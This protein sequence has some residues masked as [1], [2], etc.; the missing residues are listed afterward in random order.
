M[1]EPGCPAAPR[2]SLKVY[3]DQLGSQTRWAAICGLLAWRPTG[4]E[5]AP[6]PGPTAALQAVHSGP[7]PRGT[8][9]GG[10]PG[11]GHAGRETGVS[12]FFLPLEAMPWTPECGQVAFRTS[13]FPHR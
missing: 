12:P 6:T 13:G 5:E 2:G 7:V 8:V 9:G 4:Q 3:G 10:Q 11:R 1:D